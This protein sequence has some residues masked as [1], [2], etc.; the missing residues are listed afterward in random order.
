MSVV[1]IG[2]RGSGKTT[3]GRLLA[4][5]LWQQFLDTDDLIT[6]AAGKSIKDIFEKEG[7]AK[8]RE[9]ETVAVREAL[10]KSEHVIALGGGAV[11]KEENRDLLKHAGRKVVYLR[12]DPK[13]L[14]QRITSDPATLAMRPNLTELGGGIEEIRALLAQREPLYREV[15]SFELDVTNLSPQEAVV[16]ITRVM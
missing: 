4:D 16:H 13:V 12:C 14:H 5:R 9:L 15:M 6:N 3:V 2:Y 7:E 1:L 10:T 8:F 11:S